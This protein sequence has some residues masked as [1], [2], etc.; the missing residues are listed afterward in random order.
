VYAISEAVAQR[1]ET[2]YNKAPISVIYPP[3]IDESFLDNDFRDTALMREVGTF[4]A[5]VARLE[6]YKNIELLIEL[7]AK[8]AMTE[9][10]FIMG[11][12]PH[13]KALLQKATQLLSE[14]PSTFSIKAIKQDVTK[15]G[16]L[17]FTGYIDEVKKFQVL[18]SASASFSLNDED[19]GI[20]KVE[21][22][23]VGTPVIAYIGGSTPEVVN[24]GKNGLIFE[25]PT[26]DSLAAVI[27]LHRILTYDKTFIKES[28]RKFSTQAFHHNLDLLIHA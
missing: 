15:I 1:V 18:A 11:D 5:F 28:A 4:F 23:A 17:Y 3:S 13:K 19:F 6:S 12:G 26:V 27:K 14:K 22:L 2:F 7:A 16:P 24:H 8:S 20:T 21:S 9:K 25:D 10:I